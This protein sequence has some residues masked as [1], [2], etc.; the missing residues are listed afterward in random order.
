MDFDEYQKKASETD[1]FP[2]DNVRGESI[3]LFG[4]IGEIGTLLTCFK[5]RIRDKSAYKT[6]LTD[7]KTEMGDVLWYVANLATKYKLSLNEIAEYNIEKT[8]NLWPQVGLMAE[9]YSLYDDTFSPQEQLPR[10]LSIKFSE[11][12]AESLAPIKVAISISG[13]ST[14]DILTDNA[15]NDDGY[16]YHDVFH[17]AYAAILGWSPVLRW[18][19]KCKRKSNAMV[20]R[21]EDGAR[22]ILTEELISLYVYNYARNHNYFDGVSHVDNEVLITIR[23]L[24]QGLEVETRT[25]YEWRV[26]IL[27]GYEAFRYLTTNNGG[28]VEIDLSKRVLQFKAA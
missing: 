18:M 8:R 17:F 26:A 23:N 12:T 13:E 15:Y 11:S 22:E 9:A 21:V 25:A 2:N 10:A 7:I 16:R 1:Q 28:I 19:T 3:S 24:V 20:D 5:K 14:G 27:K 6:F 4:L